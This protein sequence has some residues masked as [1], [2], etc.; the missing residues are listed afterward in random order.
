MTFYFVKG[1]MPG[2][3]GDVPLCPRL[4]GYV[5]SIYAEMTWTGV[6]GTRVLL[7]RRATENG[8]LP[9]RV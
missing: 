8:P 9:N 3:K 1:R 5:G 2:K 4:R 7:Y 6:E